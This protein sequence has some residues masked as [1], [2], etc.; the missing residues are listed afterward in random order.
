MLMTADKSVLLVVDVQERLLPAIHDGEAVLANCIWLAGVAHRLRV[1]V[2]V[3]EQYPAGLG[4]TA[5]PLKAVLDGAHC[6]DKTH[7]S[8][9]SDCCLAGTEVEARRQVIVIGTEAHV[10][11]LQTVLE[12]RWQGKEVFVV[13]DAVGSRKPADKELA[14]ARMRAHGVEIVSREMVAFEWLKRSA[15]AQFREINQDF[16]RDN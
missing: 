14:L 4:P 8:C 3:S 16:I 11:V 5:A 7:F 15:T 12:L 10:C 6:V 1:P 2:V 9:V 13:A